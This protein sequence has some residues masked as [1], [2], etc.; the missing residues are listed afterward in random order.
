MPQPVR[1]ARRGP[2]RFNTEE[3][4]ADVEDL[5]RALGVPQLNLRGGSY[6]TRLALE[7]MRSFPSSV[8]SAALLAAETLSRS[9]V[10]ELPGAGHDTQ[11]HT[12]CVQDMLVAFFEEPTEEVN[13]S[14]VDDEL[15][16]PDF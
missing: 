3:S 15:G 16:P 13:T 5:R 10:V 4:A 12:P 7:V 9:Q 6:G 8:R 11:S 14:C 2:E 1:R